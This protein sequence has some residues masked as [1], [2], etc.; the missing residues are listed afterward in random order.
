MEQVALGSS[1]NEHYFGILTV[2][3]GSSFAI[4]WGVQ[5]F[6]GYV[7]PRTSQF[8]YSDCGIQKCTPE[9]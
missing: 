2:Q 8:W 5:N 4:T 6:L 9:Q 3:N 1:L 7:V